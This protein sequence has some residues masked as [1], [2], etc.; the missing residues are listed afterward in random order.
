MVKLEKKTGLICLLFVLYF[1]VYGF[2]SVTRSRQF[3]P[4]SM[5]YVNVAQNIR[6]GKGIVQDT[7]GFNQPHFQ[8]DAPRPSP[9]VSQPPLYPIAIAFL[10]LF[11]L[12]VASAAL[13]LSVIA[14]AL[15]VWLSYCLMKTLFGE[16]EA[17]LSSA[18]LLI[19]YPLIKVTG[20]AWS[21]PLMLLLLLLCFL[22]LV[23]TYRTK[24][25]GQG[26]PI[27]VGWVGG[28]CFLTRFSAWPLFFVIAFY[29]WISERT[30]LSLSK[31]LL[32]VFLGAVI[33]IALVFYRNGILMGAIMPTSNPSTLGLAT[34]LQQTFLTVFTRY[35]D[36]AEPK[37]EFAI[38]V[39]VLTGVCFPLVRRKQLFSTFKAV[40]F[41]RSRFSLMVWSIFYLLC[42]AVQRSL[43]HFDGINPR[44]TVPASL[45][46]VLFF[47]ALV[48]RS[49]SLKRETVLKGVGVILF[50]CVVFYGGLVVRTSP[51]TIERVL[52]K[53]E[54]LAWL[55]AHI[56]D[57]DLVIGDNTMDLPFFLGR[58]AVISFS[59]YPYT[60]YFEYRMLKAVISLNRDTY[61][62]FFL[63]LRKNFFEEE[64]WLGAYGPF[65]TDVVFER[66][67]Q[68]PEIVFVKELEDGYVFQVYSGSENPLPGDLLDV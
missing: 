27:V 31:R 25:T 44:L 3:S 15:I 36:I 19:H 32:G 61:D 4:D 11:G 7:L 50:G 12:K 30:V 22:F 20:Y 35:F 57:Q 67:A 58:K 13:I 17:Y 34:V 54:R 6:D 2:Y 37:I 53:S 8:P 24:L 47:S 38:F 46:L 39:V 28:L 52:A 21:E 16:P 29:Y 41:S 63:V 43:Y 5:N 23:N 64:A 40:F 9:L 26:Y 14:F 18:F 49:F 68:Y 45:F 42:L 33:P 66:R 60:D 55:S 65:I 51:V 10:S 62:R 59:P 56:T 48:V 1:F